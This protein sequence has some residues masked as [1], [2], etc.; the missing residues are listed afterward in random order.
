MLDVKSVM[1]CL[2][3]IKA[4]CNVWPSPQTAKNAYNIA[5]ECAKEAGY[6][7]TKNSGTIRQTLSELGDKIA[8]HGK[9]PVMTSHK[10]RVK[11]RAYAAILLA[12]KIATVYEDCAINT[13]EALKLAKC[14][15]GAVHWQETEPI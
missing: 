4:D 13:D 8:P 6:V 11:A 10:N 1:E 12:H 7:L 2:T 15:I 14:Q 5:I 9:I 3:N